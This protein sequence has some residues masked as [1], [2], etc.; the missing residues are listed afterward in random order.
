[1]TRDDENEELAEQAS[2]LM[3]VY[4]GYALML[5]LFW[6]FCLNCRIWTAYKI[7]YPHIFE[8]DERHNLD[9]RQLAAFPSFFTMLLGI[10]SWLNFF[11]IGGEEMFIYW[12]VLLLIVTAVVILL[13]VPVLRWRSRKWFIVT[14]VSDQ[15]GETSFSLEWTLTAALPAV[16]TFV[17]WIVACRVPRLLPWRPVRQLVVR[18]WCKLAL[19]VAPIMTCLK[20]T[21]T[22]HIPEYRAIFLPVLHTVARSNAMQ[23]VQLACVWSPRRHP[24]NSAQYSVHPSFSRLAH[25]VPASGQL[26]EVLTHGCFSRVSVAIPY[27]RI[28]VDLHAVCLLLCRELHHRR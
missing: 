10:F 9:W 5:Y 20:L 11:K 3:Q 16:P 4:A 28:A 23:L 25:V 14:H 8:F 26:R 7:N 22:V 19:F 12:P 1:M 17:G 18:M 15:R 21:P 2:F 27:R 6:W 24:R 13:P